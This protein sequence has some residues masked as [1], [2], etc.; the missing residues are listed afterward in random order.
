MTSAQLK[1]SGNTR[2][3]ATAV[4]GGLVA[5]G[6]ASTLSEPTTLW[7]PFESGQLWAVVPFLNESGTSIV[8]GIRVADLFTQQLQ[9]VRGINTIPV[10]RVLL[11][12]RTAGIGAL[13]TTD[14]AQDLLNT[15]GV[16]GIVVGTVTAYDPYPPPTMG[17][18][19]QLFVRT[20]RGGSGGV[21]PWTLSHAPSGD[22]AMGQRTSL[23]AVAEASGLFDARN[24]MTLAWLS[25]YAEGRTEPDGAFGAEIYLMD[26]ELYTQFVSYRLIHDLLEFVQGPV[27]NEAFPR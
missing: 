20:P 12:M 1:P 3:L 22:V 24:H 18:S 16:D 25:E 7:S 21:D 11:A 19:V 10:N 9:G 6:C 13:T 8:D 26:M 2:R 17:A 14:E 27:A 15:L 23:D 4:L 5:G